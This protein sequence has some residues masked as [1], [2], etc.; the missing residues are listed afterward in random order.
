MGWLIIIDFNSV[1]K[2]F[3]T[4]GIALMVSGG[5]FY[6]LGTVFYARDK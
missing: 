4:D 6:T 2:V 1:L 5:I 3:S